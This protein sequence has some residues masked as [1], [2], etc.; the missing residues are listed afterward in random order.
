V[1]LKRSLKDWLK[2]LVLLLDEAAV[3]VIIIVVLN[4]L[5]VKIPLPLMI[6][7]GLLVGGLV[8]V[9]HIRVVPSFHRRKVTGKEGMIGQQGE[10]V[11]PLTPVGTVVVKGE[12]WKA[13]CMDNHIETGMMV[14]IVSVE[15]LKLRVVYSQED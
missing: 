4:L 15:R 14:K 8:F 9:I 6:I 13:E 2:V 5:D 11:H 7:G 10:V 3:V 12:T 1:K